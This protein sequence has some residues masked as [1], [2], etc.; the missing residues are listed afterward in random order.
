MKADARTTIVKPCPANALTAAERAEILAVCNSAEF[1]S[2]PPGQIVP[3]LADRY[4]YLASES[5]M[6]RILRA[7]SQQHRR[8]R[9]KPA[10]RPAPPATHVATAAKQ[11]W[12]WDITYLPSSVRG[13]YY[14]L[15]LIEDIYSRKAVGWEVHG[16]ESGALAASLLQ[17]S[18]LRESCLLSPLVLHSDNG[19]P[20]KS[21]TL[22]AKMYELG[23]S[24]SRSRP[25]VSN[26]NPYSESLF[27]T[28][29]YCPQWPA[30]GFA[31]LEAARCW[32]KVFTDW[33][34]GEHRHSRIRY[35]TPNERH[36][37]KDKE[38]LKKR[39]QLYQESRRRRPER[40][41][42]QT[43]NWEPAGPVVLN[44]Q[45]DARQAQMAA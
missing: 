31:S 32:V 17:R 18:K 42:G 16:E 22:L 19:A 33:Y 39:E 15:Y 30:G 13:Q 35:V 23:V 3:R 26:D 38:I 34:N 24:P 12:T 36:A 9:S 14:Y 5:T 40:W 2:L 4:C 1:A 20:M 29:K 45:R 8:G 25:G 37:G 27:R 43:R 10:N 41:S 6:Y 28:L 44:P 7:A 11:V 21:S